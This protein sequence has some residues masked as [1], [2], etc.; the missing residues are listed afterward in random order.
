MPNSKEHFA[1]HRHHPLE[2]A[3]ELNDVPQ[4]LEV[5]TRA[6]PDRL[7][8]PKRNKIM[9]PRL[10]LLFLLSFIFPDTGAKEA[11]I[12]KQFG[13]LAGVTAYLHVHVELS[14]SSV[15][16]QLGKYWQL[17]K[18]NCDSEMAVL[19]YMLT[20]ANTSISNFT[21]RK[22]TPDHPGGLSEK[23]MIHQNAKLW[24]KVAQLHL[25]DLEDMEESVA[26]LRKSLPVIPNS[27]TGRIPVKAQFAPPEGLHI[28]NMQ[29]YVD[30]HD[31]LLTL[32]P[33]KAYTSRNTNSP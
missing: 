1:L 27:N 11:V 17:L 21:L 18:E 19:N 8:V 29:A 26:T 9:M 13:Q 31:H 7:P 28:V 2:M 4:T 22:E 24:Y 23:S 12:F 10:L 20:Y 15:E 16:A 33:E 30:T 6:H 14:I 5:R 25:R 3:A 32:V